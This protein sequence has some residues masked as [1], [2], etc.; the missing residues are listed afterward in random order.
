MPSAHQAIHPSECGTE[1]IGMK[2]NTYPYRAEQ[3]GASQR[4]K[5]ILQWADGVAGPPQLFTERSD[6]ED[7]EEGQRRA[8]RELRRGQGHTHQVQCRIRPEHNAGHQQDGRHI[9]DQRSDALEI[10]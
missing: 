1:R 2:C 7:R 3:Q 8:R 10:K 9:P 5:A 6:Q 4:A